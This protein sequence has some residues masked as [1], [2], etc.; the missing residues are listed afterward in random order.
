MKPIII[1]AVKSPLSGYWIIQGN[2]KFI[3]LGV[4]SKDAAK[5]QIK[6]LGYSIIAS[7]EEVIKISK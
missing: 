4:K 5:N 2:D 6:K 3:E 7:Y 1:E